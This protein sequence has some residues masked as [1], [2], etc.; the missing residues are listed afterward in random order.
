M[1]GR[2]AWEASSIW[3]G[4]DGK[5]E[6]VLTIPFPDSLGCFYSGFTEHLSFQPNS[7]EW[8]VMGLA[9]YGRPGADLRDFI[10]LDHG[11][12]RVN[13]PAL[14]GRGNRHVSAIA[15]RLGLRRHPGSDIHS[16]HHY[17]AFSV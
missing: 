11:L 15:M 2:G 9:P 12:Y 17:F 16:R 4:H 10:A 14:L 7:D 6:H 5:L 3:H 1:D 13:A 8:K